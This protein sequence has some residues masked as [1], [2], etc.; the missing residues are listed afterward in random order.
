MTSGDVLASGS[1]SSSKL[2]WSAPRSAPASARGGPATAVA[3]GAV[4]ESVAEGSEPDG[5]EAT[6]SPPPAL[7]SAQEQWLD[8]LHQGT[9]VLLRVWLLSVTLGSTLSAANIVLA[10]SPRSNILTSVLVFIRI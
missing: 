6:A 2:S 7:D 4:M 5:S 3:C 9:H 10:P 1:Q 8:M